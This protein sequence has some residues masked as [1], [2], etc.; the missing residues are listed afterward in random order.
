MVALHLPAE[1][2]CLCNHP[3]DD[4]LTK[5]QAAAYVGTAQD[6]LAVR[7]HEELSLPEMLELRHPDDGHQWLLE[8]R[9]TVGAA[10]RGS[11]LPKANVGASMALLEELEEAVST[12]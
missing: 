4:G 1:G 9:L 6:G 11:H 2:Q 8:L 10:S 12:L 5:W 7:S 3:L